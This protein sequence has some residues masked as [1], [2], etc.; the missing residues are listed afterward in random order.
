MGACI[1]TSLLTRT[2]NYSNDMATLELCDTID[3]TITIDA[4]LGI[5]TINLG[6]ASINSI[7]HA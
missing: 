4:I 7:A 6:I 3:T 2:S 5:N 1:H